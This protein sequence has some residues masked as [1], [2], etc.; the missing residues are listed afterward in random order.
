MIINVIFIDDK[1]TTCNDQLKVIKDLLPEKQDT[2]KGDE[3][4]TSDFSFELS[5]E[6][7]IHFSAYNLK[8][9]QKEIDLSLI[10]N[11]VK[12]PNDQEKYLFVIDLCLDDSDPATGVN[13]GKK[14]QETFNSNATVIYTT[15]TNNYWKKT[16]GLGEDDW[17]I[18][19]KTSNVGEIQLYALANNISRYYDDNNY[20]D[21]CEKEPQ[22][23]EYYNFLK[24]MLTSRYINKQYFGSIL[25]KCELLFRGE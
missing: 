3:S 9:Q 25:L 14:I 15:S 17:L 11:I 2:K 13:V 21:K 10:E 1:E 18:P 5:N 24:D 8:V 22:S 12:N 23:K 20:N 16:L 19:R 6:K 7:I 4:S